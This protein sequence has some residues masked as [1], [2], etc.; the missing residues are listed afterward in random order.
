MRAAAP[1]KSKPVR[2]EQIILFRVSGHIFAVSSASVQ[3][4]RSADSM[5]GMTVELNA[6][7]LRKVRHVAQRGDRSLFVVN[8]AAHFGLAPSPGTLIFVLRKTRTALLIDGIEKM[9]SMTRLQALPQ[10]FF[11]EERQWYRG[12]TALDQT[13]V[14][15]VD[16]DG[17]L[18]TEELSLL[19]AA[20]LR[21]EN[22]AREKVEGTELPQ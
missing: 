2:T 10:S 3:E 17:F 16:P 22:I 1:A 9:T 7:A 21:A 12:L 14:P 4:V 18:S 5:A 8:G 11:H 6:P 13:V 19:D 15:V 20:L